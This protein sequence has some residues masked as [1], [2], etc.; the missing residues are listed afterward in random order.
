M[1][2][3]RPTLH[4]MDLSRGGTPTDQPS[5]AERLRAAPRP[6]AAA[7]SDAERRAT[8]L[9]TDP[10]APFRGQVRCRG[11]ERISH[12]VY[13]RHRPDLGEHDRFLRSLH[14]WLLVLPQGARFTHLTGA[15]LRGWELPRLPEGVPVFAAVTGDRPR[16]RRPGLLC[17]RLVTA[18]DEVPIAQGLPVDTPEEVLLRC[19]RDLGHLDLRILIES[20]ARRGDLDRPRMRSLLESGRPGVRPLRE[21]WEAATALT[22]SVG[23][24][25]LDTFHAA[26]RVPVERQVDLAD[27]DGV[28]LGRG[29]LL[30]TG[31]RFV[32]EY[33]G[34]GH[35]DGRQHREDLRRDRKLLSA[36]Y[37][38][39]GYTLDDL[40]NHGT[41]V[42][43]EIDRSLGRP[44]DLRHHRR[45]QRLVEESLYSPT[46][47]RRLLN[48]WRRATGVVDWPGPA[49]VPPPIAA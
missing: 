13:H 22:E 19:A 21:A 41:V 26:I 31:T 47:R 48:R 33:D 20:A 23:E 43:H 24:T 4:L 6:A 27:A 10:D 49:P 15:R 32:H 45:W 37:Q 7:R 36:G 9:A 11:Y 39:R 17:A 44:H 2:V 40:V 5:A 38:R 18:H 8:D 42:L 3:D 35:R 1:S 34:A 29:D 46:G 28:L 12:G 25:I 16:P 30:V 14:A